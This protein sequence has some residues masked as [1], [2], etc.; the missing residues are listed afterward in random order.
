MIMEIE[1]QY[2]HIFNFSG[3]GTTVRLTFSQVLKT[4]RRS[5]LHLSET[6]SENIT[7]A[8]GLYKLL[9]A[10]TD[11]ISI[12]QGLYASWNLAIQNFSPGRHS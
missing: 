9:Y 12:K 1:S 6:S 8:Q 4:S 3:L 5:L 11:T 10:Y 2:N 7:I